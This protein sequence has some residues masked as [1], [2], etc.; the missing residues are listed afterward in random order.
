MIVG[1]DPGQK[2]GLAFL[3]DDGQRIVDVMALPYVGKQVDVGALDGL[4]DMVQPAF[5][6]IELQVIRQQQAGA[7]TIATNYGRL[8]CVHELW[9]R[10][11][12]IVTPKDWMKRAGLPAGLKHGKPRNDAMYLAAKK[13]WGAQIGHLKPSHDGQIAAL[14]I[15]R[16]GAKA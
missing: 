6:W 11:H 8:L 10:P 5:S 12:G 9:S 7:M 3:A 14:L 1:I 2:G 4:L 13:L 16:Y 15:A